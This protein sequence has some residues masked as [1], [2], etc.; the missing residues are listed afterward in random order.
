[1][2]ID[3][4]LL[5]DLEEFQG[6]Y[7]TV[8]DHDEVVASIIPKCIEEFSVISDFCWCQYGDSFRCSKLTHGC[9]LEFSRSTNWFWRIGDSK[10]NF[11][12]SRRNDVFEDSS[13]KV[14]CTE[15][16]DS[17]HGRKYRNIGA[18]INFAALFPDATRNIAFF[19]E[20]RYTT[21][22]IFHHM[23]RSLLLVFICFFFSAIGTVFASDINDINVRDINVTT[24]G[25]RN[26]ML[27]SFI[28]PF[29]EFFFSAPI[30]GGE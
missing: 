16:S 22:I 7:A 24:T 2:D 10:S 14:W 25:V 11:K 18:K 17:Y 30:L 1:M 4:Y 19:D 5:R 3:A 26:S 23:I 15:K 9:R 21:H 6:K 27:E 8:G 29:S 20:N 12:S 28:A 13:S